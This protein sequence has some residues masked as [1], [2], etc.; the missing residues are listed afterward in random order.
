MRHQLGLRLYR[1]GK[2][3]DQ[4]LSNLLMQLLASALEQ[5]LIGC[6]PNKCVLEKISSPWGKPF[7]GRDLRGF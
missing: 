5:R 7:K 6:V 1:L 3:I 2:L 4:H